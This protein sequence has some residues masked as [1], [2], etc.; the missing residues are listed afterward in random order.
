METHM[1]KKILILAMTTIIALLTVCN[2]GSGNKT[3]QNSPDTPAVD[4]SGDD[5]VVTVF[6]KFPGGSPAETGCCTGD[7]NYFG[8]MKK[9]GS[10]VAN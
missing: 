8:H 2:N 6:C 1:H 9:L 3:Q 7:K 4:P 5:Q 10:E